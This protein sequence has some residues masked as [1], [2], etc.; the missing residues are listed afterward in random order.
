MPLQPA[1]VEQPAAPVEEPKKLEQV[2]LEQI[3]KPVPKP[4]QPPAPEQPESPAPA[5]EP[6]KNPE[7]IIKKKILDSIFK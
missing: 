4:D 1:P 2:L 3:V 5:P 6:E 7:E